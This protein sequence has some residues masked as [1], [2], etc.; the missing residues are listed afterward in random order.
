MA[1][2]FNPFSGNL[3]Y[4]N[5]AFTAVSVS[6][7][8]TMVSGNTYLVNTTSGAINMTLPAP[9]LNAYVRIK[10]SHGTFDTNNVTIVRNG[11]EKIETV[12]ASYI[13]NSELESVTIVSDGT[14]WFIL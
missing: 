10:D 7:N 3:D 4:V 13:L 9:A 8:T 5:D 2:L 1:V 12:A 14:D 11:S 6:T